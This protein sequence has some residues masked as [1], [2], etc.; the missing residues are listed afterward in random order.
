MRYTKESMKA[1]EWISHCDAA[2]ELRVTRMFLKEVA[3]PLFGP[4]NVEKTKARSNVKGLIKA[5]G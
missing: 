1:S 3:M 4:P 2:G 5:L